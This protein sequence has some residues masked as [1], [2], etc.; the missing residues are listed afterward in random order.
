MGKRE[1]SRPGP[2]AGVDD[3]GYG[4]EDKEKVRE[5]VQASEYYKRY[6]RFTALRC[7][8][9]AVLDEAGLYKRELT[10]WIWLNLPYGLRSLVDDYLT[11]GSIFR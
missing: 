5:D 7:R 4:K 2:H 8:L 6:K 11:K 10:P 9:S 1:F 3:G